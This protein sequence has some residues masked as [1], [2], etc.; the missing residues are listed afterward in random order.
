MSPEGSNIT[1][2]L[3]EGQMLLQIVPKEKK[4][5]NQH[6]KWLNKFKNTRYLIVTLQLQYMYTGDVLMT[7]LIKKITKMVC[8]TKYSNKIF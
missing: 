8:K 1:I 5:L 6:T 3:Q 7:L 2:C 4:K